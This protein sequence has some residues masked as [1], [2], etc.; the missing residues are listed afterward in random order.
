MKKFK[1]NLQVVLD[2]RKR[3]EEELLMQLGSL[4]EEERDEA[5]KLDRLKRR[6]ETAQEELERALKSGASK[7]NVERKD[8]YTKTVQDDVKL[9]ELTLSAVRVRVEE[10][11]AE[12]VDA[13]KERKVIEAFRDRKENE[14]ILACARLEQ[15]MLDEIASV[16]YARGE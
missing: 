5:L 15:N 13:V 14:Y 3:K 8:L 4:L 16:R 9:Q 1:F 10:K 7:E 12:V 11:R 6:L 2:Q